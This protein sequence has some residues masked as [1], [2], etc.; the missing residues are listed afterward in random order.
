VADHNG[1][2]AG[3]TSLP[4]WRYKIP[5]FIY[6]PGIIKPL[7]VNKLSSQ[8]DLMPTLFSIMNWSYESKFYGEDILDEN[9]RERAFIGTYEKL[10]FLRDHRLVILEPNKILHE[11]KIVHQGIHDVE[12]KEIDSVEA[13]ELDAIAYYQSESYFYKLGINRWKH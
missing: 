10:G 1:G 11:Y 13:D 12:Y 2:S 5:L 4:A 6:G 3:E 7:I 8:I 9:F